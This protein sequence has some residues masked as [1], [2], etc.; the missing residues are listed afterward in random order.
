[1]D[2]ITS[3]SQARVIKNDSN[4]YAWSRRFVESMT[5]VAYE[6][7]QLMQGILSVCDGVNAHLAQT[8]PESWWCRGTVPSV[9]RGTPDEQPEV[10]PQ[11]LVI[12][13]T[14][15]I[16]GLG[17]EDPA[18]VRVG[19]FIVGV[20]NQPPKFATVADVHP[21]EFF[22]QWM[23]ERAGDDNLPANQAIVFSEILK[24]AYTKGFRFD[25]MVEDDDRLT[26]FLRTKHELMTMRFDFNHI[27]LTAIEFD[28]QL[29]LQEEYIQ[30]N[31]PTGG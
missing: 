11:Q 15:G 26:L 6:Q 23:S 14:S 28:R 30:S 2:N 21:N 20:N 5:E 27:R 9:M 19:Q 24:A 22:E 25:N 16:S 4:F 29:K 8:T 10:L 7:T 17:L 1:M 31:P 12:N 3:L 13:F 18:A